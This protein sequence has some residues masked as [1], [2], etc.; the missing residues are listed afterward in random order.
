MKLP[1]ELVQFMIRAFMCACLEKLAKCLS[2]ES[3]WERIVTQR[4]QTRR[5]QLKDQPP[6]LLKHICKTVPKR[7]VKK[8]KSKAKPGRF[9]VFSALMK[10]MESFRKFLGPNNH[11]AIS[12]DKNTFMC[13]VPYAHI[14]RSFTEQIFEKQF[15][16]VYAENGMVPVYVDLRVQQSGKLLRKY[17]DT[18]MIVVFVLSYKII[19]GEKFVKVIVPDSHSPV[20]KIYPDVSVRGLVGFLPEKYVAHG[21][22]K[23]PFLHYR[24]EKER[25]STLTF[26][27][28]PFKVVEHV[29]QWGA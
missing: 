7:C 16:V 14:I 4:G 15:S 8:P 21:F 5:V 23:N 6:A 2:M 13:V 22:S 17:E 12:L 10:D 24:Y 19:H 3:V 28:R 27:F 11:M 18:N 1:K 25:L 26:G 9:V 29:V 20:V